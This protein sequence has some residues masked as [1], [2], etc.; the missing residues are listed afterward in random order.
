[1]KRLEIVEKEAYEEYYLS[2]DYYFEVLAVLVSSLRGVPVHCASFVCSFGNTHGQL[3]YRVKGRCVAQ[4]HFYC[5][6]FFD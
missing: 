3:F 6:R 5:Y 4:V 1:M 2:W